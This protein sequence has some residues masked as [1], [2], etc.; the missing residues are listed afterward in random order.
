MA[1]DNDI[2][3]WIVF[4][5]KNSIPIL[6]G[7]HVYNLADMKPYNKDNLGP[8]KPTEKQKFTN[9][10]F[11]FYQTSRNKL[12]MSNTELHNILRLCTCILNIK[13]MYKEQRINIM[14]I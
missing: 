7:M 5:I 10:V 11:F 8:N 3:H 1:D 13:K 12:L 6:I 9:Y 4:Y 2:N 14:D